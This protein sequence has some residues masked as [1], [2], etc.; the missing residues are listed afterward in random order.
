[1]GTVKYFTR[2]G[3]EIVKGNM[4]PHHGLFIKTGEREEHY[5]GGSHMVWNPLACS[6]WSVRSRWDKMSY[7]TCEE[8]WNENNY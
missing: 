7:K 3:Y 5:T 6:S 1:M 2:A 8:L 4:E